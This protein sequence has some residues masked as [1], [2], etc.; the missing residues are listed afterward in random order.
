MIWIQMGLGALT[1]LSLFFTG[2]KRWQG[3]AIAIVA[4]LFWWPYYA[5]TEQW[6]LFPMQG[7]FLGMI[8]WNL[9][10]WRRDERD[11]KET[12]RN[13]IAT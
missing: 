6:G 7:A 1:V 10:Q 2:K 9:V 4:N 3:W 13:L 12:G 5:F 8:I 11:G